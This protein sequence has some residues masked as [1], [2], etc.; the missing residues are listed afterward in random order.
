MQG[1]QASR[2]QSQ[3]HSCFTRSGSACQAFRIGSRAACYGLQGRIDPTL[4]RPAQLPEEALDS[5]SVRVAI[6]RLH[7]LKGASTACI[8]LPVWPPAPSQ[9]QP[10]MVGSSAQAPQI[11]AISSPFMFCCHAHHRRPVMGS[12]AIRYHIDRTSSRTVPPGFTATPIAVPRLGAPGRAAPA[13]SRRP[14]RSPGPP[15]N[16]TAFR[17]CPSPLFSRPPGPGGCGLRVVRAAV[18][19]AG[20]PVAAAACTGLPTV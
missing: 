11:R 6:G 10:S 14:T 5:D 3:P 19:S 15:F 9:I 8:S 17:R 16:P 4:D 12:M 7:H 1:L 2:I 18:A 20:S 13:S